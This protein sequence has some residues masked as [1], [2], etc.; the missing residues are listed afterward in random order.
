MI[1]FGSAFSLVVIVRTREV[2]KCNRML[3]SSSSQKKRQKE[4]LFDT[5]H[6][7]DWK[8]TS[9]QLQRCLCQWSEPLLTW[10]WPEEEHMDFSNLLQTGVCQHWY[11]DFCKLLHGFVEVVPGIP[12]PCQTKPSWSLTKN[13]ELIEASALTYSC[14]LSQSTQCLGSVV[15][16]AMFQKWFLEHLET[17]L[18]RE[19]QMLEMLSRVKM[20]S[21]RIA[22]GERTG[23]VSSCGKTA[24]V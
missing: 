5:E 6:K 15:P 20:L 22:G 11:M 10:L 23:R 17:W 1:M 2:S 8:E 19:A 14:L 24:E 9:V 12:R 7:E 18:E 3:E 13:S 21:W 4:T 16:L